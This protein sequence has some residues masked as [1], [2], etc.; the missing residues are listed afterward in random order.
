MLIKESAS[1][2]GNQTN[3]RTKKLSFSEQS[4][5]QSLFTTFN[6]PAPQ[7][8]KPDT[9]QKT[10]P[11]P[12]PV[13]SVPVQQPLPDKTAESSNQSNTSSNAISYAALIVALGAAGIAYRKPSVILGQAVLEKIAQA[14]VKETEGVKKEVSVCGE[15]LNSFGDKIKSFGEILDPVEKKFKSFEYKLKVLTDG[16]KMT[17]PEHPAVK[18]VAEKL[19]MDNFELALHVDEAELEK[20][21][22]DE[23]KTKI[24]DYLFSKP[25]IEEHIVNNVIP[26]DTKKAIE[27]D[28]K[29]RAPVVID[30]YKF[31][32]NGEDPKDFT[33]NSKNFLSK[34]LN[35]PNDEN[36]S[37]VLKEQLPPILNDPDQKNKLIENIINFNLTHNYKAYLLDNRIV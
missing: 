18:T 10:A 11:A 27:E 37:E 36:L 1:F 23:D 13:A 32:L 28:L 15:K 14:A 7:P 26:A 2:S 34:Y 3:V 30:G 6:L 17:D 12:A 20:L 9:F 5:Q 25:Q 31:K 8:P 4:P 33:P 21:H 24:V 19:K 35:I 22:G 29:N 16:V